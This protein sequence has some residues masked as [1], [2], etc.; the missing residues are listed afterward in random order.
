MNPLHW[1]RE[2][3]RALL[4]SI[5]VGVLLGLIHGVRSASPIFGDQNNCETFVSWLRYGDSV[6]GHDFSPILGW[7]LL[8]GFLGAAII[9]IWQLMRP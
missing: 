4:L 9:Y 8:G 1:K 5:G 6:C 2:H 7:P 3:Q